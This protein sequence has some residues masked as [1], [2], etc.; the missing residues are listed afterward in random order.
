MNSILQVMKRDRF[1][2]ILRFVHLNDNR[3]YKKGESGHDPLYKLRPFLTPLVANFQS[4]YILHREISVDETMIGFKGRLGFIQHMPK[5]PTKWGMKAYALSNTRT[6]YIY[7]WYLYTSLKLS[8]SR[9]HVHVHYCINA[10]S[11]KDDS[12]STTENG[13]THAVAMKFVSPLKDRGHHVYTGNFYTSPCLFY[14]LRASGFGACGTL[15]ISRRGLPPA[16]K[17]K[18]RKGDKR[19]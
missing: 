18:M 15:T 10:T 19:S 13:M 5:K 3:H 12:I 7:S 2:L 16:I 8:M 4:A 1:T 14:E 17:L 6:G 9:I 11:G